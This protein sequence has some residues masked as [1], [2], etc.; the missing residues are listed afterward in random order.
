M[1][2][3]GGGGARRA[4][5]LESTGGCVGPIDA[6]LKR[7]AGSKRLNEDGD[8]VDF[9]KTVNHSRESSAITATSR[10]N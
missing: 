5:K 3:V 2:S 7:T 4:P 6:D 10:L 9:M 1:A 8:C